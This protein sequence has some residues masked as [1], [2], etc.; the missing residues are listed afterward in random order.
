[1]FNC[2][3]AWS[4]VEYWVKDVSETFSCAVMMSES[5]GSQHYVQ[6]WW[7]FWYCRTISWKSL[8]L[9]VWVH[10]W[11]TK[12][13]HSLSHCSSKENLHLAHQ[14]WWLIL[15]FSGGDKQERWGGVHGVTG[16]CCIAR[17]WPKWSPHKGTLASEP[18]LFT[19]VFMFLWEVSCLWMH[20]SNRPSHSPALCAECA[21]MLSVRF[22]KCARGRLFICRK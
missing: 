10:A 17:W 5:D 3:R 12:S 6:T 16:E 8:V 21:T 9:V 1:M 15:E 20:N 22:Y 13:V 14:Q 7:C 11:V 19:A 18:R 4:I 2:L